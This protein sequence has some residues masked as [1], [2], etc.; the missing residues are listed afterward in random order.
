MNLSAFILIMYKTYYLP[1]FM[2]GTE[3]WTWTKRD[4][5]RLQAVWN[6]KG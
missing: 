3:T 2:Y 5:N 4:A 6:F 1:V